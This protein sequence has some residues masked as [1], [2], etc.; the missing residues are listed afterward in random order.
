MPNTQ[1]ITVAAIQL[2]TDIGNVSRNLQQCRAL[3]LEARAQGARWIA[4]PEF[5]NTGFCWKPELADCIEDDSGVSLE[6]LRSLSQELGIVIGGSLLYREP[7]GGVRN[8]YFCFNEGHLVG[9]HDKDLPTMWES[10]LYEAGDASDTGAL[11]RADEIRIGSAV[12]W[13]F[14][15]TAT[16]R[17]LRGKI[18]ILLGGSNW[19]SIPNNW[20]TWLASHMETANNQNS[21]QCVQDTARLLGVPIVHAAHCNAFDCPTPGLPITYQGNMEGN[22]AIIDGYGQVLAMR[23]WDEGQGVVIAQVTPGAVS[24][25]L[26]PIPDS[27]WLRTR[28]VIPTLSWHY[29]GFLGRRYYKKHVKQT[30]KTS[31]LKQQKEVH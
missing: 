3:V 20:P 15:R 11:G 13:E 21:L 12:C 22:T 7:S 26:P 8:R 24:N 14:M 2:D 4:L 25:D 29:H 30:Y 5:F 28:G 9:V 18:D 10:S 31:T 17:R 6:F 19:W 27:F 1:P 16:S 23:S